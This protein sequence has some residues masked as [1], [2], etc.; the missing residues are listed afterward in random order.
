MASASRARTSLILVDQVVATL[1][2]AV[3]TF[4]EL[5]VFVEVLDSDE[6]MGLIDRLRWVSKA[7][8]LGEINQRLQLHKR[9]LSLM[10]V[11]L[12]W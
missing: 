8:A 11:I 7:K 1:A 6:K 10:L 5:D 2:G 3:T 4:S 12:T 9:S